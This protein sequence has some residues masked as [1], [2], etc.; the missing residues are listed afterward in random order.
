MSALSESVIDGR[1]VKALL[2]S[3][4][5]T[6]LRGS[7]N[8]MDP[9]G[10]ASGKM[11]PILAVMAVKLFI[12][13]GLGAM[14]FFVR[15][16][17]T[18]A[19]LVFSTMMVF[20]AM[21]VLLEFSNLILRPDEYSII[22][23]LPVGSKTFFAAKMIHLLAYVNALALLLYLPPAVAAAVANR[24]GR[25]L[26]GFLL[27]GALAATAMGLLFVLLYALL[28]R[29]VD[30]E[31]MQRV[32]GYANLALTLVVY[33]GY[34]V[35]P[36]ILEGHALS[37]I[38][39]FSSG[40]IY[41][42]PPAWFAAVVK[43]LA[44]EAAP[45]D[46]GA[47][48]FALA[49]LAVAFRAAMS[50]LSLEY[51]GTLA[52][53]VGR[54]E[55]LRKR[56]RNG[57]GSRLLGLLAASED[58]AVWT[59]IRKQFKYDNRFKMS[60][61]SILPLTAIY[62]FLGVSEGRM[63]PDPFLAPPGDAAAGGYSLLYIAAAL[64]PY[65]ITLGTVNSDAYRSAWVFYASPADRTR[66]ILSPARYALIWF[67]LPF[68][69]LLAGIFTWYFGSAVHAMLH[70]LVIY[71]ILVIQTRILTLLYP[72]IPFSQPPK[73]GQRTLYIFVLVLLSIIVMCVPMGI[74][75]AL[76]YGGYAGYAAWLAAAMITNG[77][78][79]RIIGRT[80]PRRAARMEFTAP[81]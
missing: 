24:N 50:K 66:I 61:L 39:R 8:P 4:W 78:L 45:R 52:D 60:I 64:F 43:L 25:L 20:L 7:G 12:G 19:F 2:G 11:P 53:T 17:F 9:S 14:V 55:P 37:A 46:I 40:W 59:L 70:C 30:R 5:K 15:E 41:L 22:A 51:A 1:Q 49:L 74:V 73:T 3:A 26:P 10:G 80:I 16:P 34:F 27:A 81:V 72:R 13:L 79:S 54:D 6:D 33:L 77:I 47:S 58:R 32:L 42:A 71:A 29:I 69:L 44:G 67:C 75:T 76:G 62:V 21:T 23:A 48:L 35:A 56:G 38:P 36:R 65:M 28:L 68:T 31:V 18:A 57:W 63:T